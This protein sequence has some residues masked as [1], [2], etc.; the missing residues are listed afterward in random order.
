MS[1]SKKLDERIELVHDYWIDPDSREIWIHGI[2]NTGDEEGEPGVDHQMATRVIKN[3][4]YLRKQSTRATVTIHLHTCGGYVG[5]GF[6]IYDTIRLM[7]YPVTIISYTHARS[8][9]SVILQAAAGPDDTRL[10]LPSSH[11]M[12]HFGSYE[13]H[14][15]SQQVYSEID[16][17]KKYDEL[18]IDIYI[19]SVKNG[20]KF[21]GV[22]DK[23]IRKE[24]IDRMNSK[25]DVYLTAEEAVEWGFADGILETWPNT[26]KWKRGNTK[27]V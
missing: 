23:R 25:V 26:C 7:P 24:L 1:D 14:G 15:I 10:L 13:T 6:A 8:M 19:E 5:E 3:L 21:K 20:K 17:F 9:S 16:F 2:D 11:F 18:M 12:F 27:K 22:T 4:H